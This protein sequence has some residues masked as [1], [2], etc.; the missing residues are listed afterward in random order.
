MLFNTNTKTEI[1]NEVASE[2]SD[3]IKTPPLPL[4]AIVK[5]FNASRKHLDYEPFE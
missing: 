5:E 4:N 3:N 2:N 1:T